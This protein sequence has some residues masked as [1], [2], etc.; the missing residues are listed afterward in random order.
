MRYKRIFT[1]IVYACEIGNIYIINKRS[2]RPYLD[3]A[4]LGLDNIMWESS[5]KLFK[6]LD[7]NDII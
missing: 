4:N 5:A 6:D 3:L 7:W 1:H 2:S